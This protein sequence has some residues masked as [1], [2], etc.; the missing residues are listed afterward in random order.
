MADLGPVGDALKVIHELMVD[1]W[2]DFGTG[3]AIVPPNVRLQA[4]TYILDQTIGKSTTSVEVSGSVQLESLMAAVLVNPD[5]DV[6]HSV[7]EGE[8]AEEEPD[9]DDDAGGP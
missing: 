2:T 3:N 6:A 4:A 5:G 8:M 7:I 1:D 9:E